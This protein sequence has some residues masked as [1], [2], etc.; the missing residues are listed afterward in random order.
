MMSDHDS[1]LSKSE[2]NDTV[3]CDNCG[4]ARARVRRTTKTFGRGRNLVLI[5]GVPVVV[6]AACGESYLTAE[7]IHEIER[8]RLHRET[9]G[10][11]RDVQVVRFAA[12]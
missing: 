6:C 9:L 11:H 4:K 7:T 8:L 10:V 12:R 1:G 2:E 3:I 5:E